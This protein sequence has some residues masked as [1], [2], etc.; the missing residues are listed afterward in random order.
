MIIST[1][2]LLILINQ[3]IYC[4]SLVP[5][6]LE[7]WRLKTAKGLSDGLVLFFLNAFIALLFYFFCLDLPISYRVSVITQ[8]LLT[9]VLVG[10]RFWYDQ[11]PHKKSLAILYGVNFIAIFSLIPLAFKYPHNVGHIAGWVGVALLVVNRVPQI[12]KI[13]RERSVFGFSYWFA[14]LLGI[15]SVMEFILV[16]V[17]HLP[18]Q[19][20]ATSS[21]A[22]ISFLIFTAQ[23]YFFSWRQR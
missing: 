6:I 22:F 23:F 4:Y 2:E 11:F 19:T 17:Y 20:M 13:Q 8:T 5:L 1:F 18:M 21:W 14:L 7:N 10:Q 16:V 3:S 9:C 15:A 12:I